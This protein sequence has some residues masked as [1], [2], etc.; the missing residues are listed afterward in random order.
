MAFMALC[1]YAAGLL[2]SLGFGRATVSPSL[3][4]VAGQ[5]RTVT[6]MWTAK[7]LQDFVTIAYDYAT[8]CSVRQ[9]HREV[10]A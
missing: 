8:G 9:I 3:S 10:S 4:A 7:G 1:G 2:C 6:P 5:K